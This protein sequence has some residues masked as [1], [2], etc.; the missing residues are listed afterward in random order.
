MIFVVNF[1][2]KKQKKVEKSKLPNGN[3]LGEEDPFAE[4]DDDVARIAKEL[5]AKYVSFMFC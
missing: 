1:L 5:E 3:P 2:Q 4:N